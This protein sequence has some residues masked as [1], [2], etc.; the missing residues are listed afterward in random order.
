MKKKILL[1]SLFLVIAGMTLKLVCWNLVPVFSRDST[2]Y[3][4][5][6]QKWHETNHFSAIIDGD[7]SFYFPPLSLY[8]TH[9]LMKTGLS[10]PHA[11]LTLNIF[12]GTMI[13]L[14][15]FGIA[16]ELARSYK[17]AVVASVLTLLNPYLNQLSIEVQRDAGYLFFLGLAL[18]MLSMGM[19]RNKN[20]CWIFFGA[21][22]A[23][24]LLIRFETLELFFIIIFCCC[25]NILNKNCSWKKT[26]YQIFLCTASFLVCMVLFSTMMETNL[27]IINK[28]PDFFL[29]K[30]DKVA[31]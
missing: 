1:W 31:D 26:F 11:G 8:L 13:P 24:A 18:W 20:I 23:C 15:V 28:Y 4:Q 19:K 2:F 16:F 3:L 17:F 10:A 30:Y 27:F 22:T 9:L 6:I 12:F 29:R 21:F 5:I 14:I 7:K 25:S